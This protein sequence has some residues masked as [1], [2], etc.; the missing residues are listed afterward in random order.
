LVEELS[1]ERGE[2][3]GETQAKAGRGAHER[4][5]PL[6]VDEGF[7]SASGA[8]EAQTAV[9]GRGPELW[10]ELEGAGQVLDGAS[11]VTARKA[12]HAEAQVDAGVRGL[13]SGGGA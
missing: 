6:E 5:G 7:L 11:I 1:C 8:L 3:L 2:L 9:E 10:S 13:P 12:H 4:A